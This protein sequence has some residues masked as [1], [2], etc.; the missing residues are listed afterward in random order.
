MQ[1]DQKNSNKP[2]INKLKD[3]EIKKILKFASDV[4]QNAYSPYSKFK[5]GAC[6]LYEDGN[7]YTGCNVE[8]AS[9]GLT[10]CAER[11]AIS[12]AIADGQKSKI[13][14]IAIYSPNAKLCYPCGACRQWIAEFSKDASIIVENAEGK[15]QIFSIKE[16][17][18]HTFEL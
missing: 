14:A 17:L 18:P 8:N 13:V 6:V 15:P 11:T 1:I 16:L 10:L 5:V 2:L 4:A 3:G 12:S 7:A 9:Y